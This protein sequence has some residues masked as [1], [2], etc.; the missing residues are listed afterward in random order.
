MTALILGGTKRKK[1]IW[2]DTYNTWQLE[3][4]QKSPEDLHLALLR[5]YETHWNERF[6][7]QC[8]SHRSYLKHSQE[9]KINISVIRTAVIIDTTTSSSRL[10]IYHQSEKC[11]MCL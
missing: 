5:S 11:T 10:D 2:M 8:A 4:Y 3:T 7:H 6:G 9:N 1:N